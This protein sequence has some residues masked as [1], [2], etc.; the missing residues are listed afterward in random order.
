MFDLRI[1]PEA[2]S[3]APQI[4]ALFWLMVVL[5]GVVTIGVFATM[6]FFLVKYR[7]GSRADRSKRQPQNLGIESTW[8]LVPLAIFLA[9]FVWSIVLYA[10]VHTP[11][12]DAETIYVVAKQWMWKVQ[13]PGGQREINELHVPLGK[14]IRLVM[15]SQDV[16]HSFAVPAFR[17]KQDVLPA[18]YTVL[19]FTPTELGRFHIFCNQYCGLDHAQMRG[20]VS[21]MPPADYAR[22]LDSNAGR[23]SLAAQGAELF[24]SSGCIGCHG[25][26]SLVHAPNL[27]GI[28]GR[29]VKLGDGSTVVADDRYIRDSILLPRS[30]VVAG[31][32]PIMPSFQGQLSE[33]DVLALIAY[34]KSTSSAPTQPPSAG[35]QSTTQERARPFRSTLPGSR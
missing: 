19:W 27:D 5:C 16:I 24:R 8:T 32:M 2:S 17:V 34:L 25:A 14:P 18:R 33:S 30:Q 9:V 12:D 21:V 3:I 6:A 29:V 20:A 4:D 35:S 7:R 22:W 23:S 28:L 26:Q 31:F 13:H 1:L 10:K 11:P 15:T